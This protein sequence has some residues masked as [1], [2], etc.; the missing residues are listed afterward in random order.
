MFDDLPD[1]VDRVVRRPR[2][3]YKCDLAESIELQ[4]PQT[5]QLEACTGLDAIEIVRTEGGFGVAAI[6]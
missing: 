1:D 4:S 6:A 5:L 3:I 2:R